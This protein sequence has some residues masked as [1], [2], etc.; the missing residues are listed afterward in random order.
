MLVVEHTNWIYILVNMVN[1]GIFFQF[2]MY[3]K[4][5]L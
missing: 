2:G 4:G 5:V 1:I 3:V